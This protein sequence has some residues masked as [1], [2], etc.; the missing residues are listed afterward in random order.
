[1]T[2]NIKTMKNII[3][4]L[5]VVLCLNS[6]G[7]DSQTSAITTSDI[8]AS[9]TESSNNRAEILKREEPPAKKVEDVTSAVHDKIKSKSLDKEQKE[10]KQEQFKKSKNREKSCTDL[11]LEYEQL[12]DKIVSDKTN[13]ENLT[14]LKSW[15]ND[16]FHNTCLNDNAD[17]Q[18]KYAEINKKL[19]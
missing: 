19:G 5:F 15:A 18:K 16:I 8:P 10:I 4:L 7:S 11:I 12:I 6:C 9:V 14:K 17:Y 1:M 2:D 13:L 3:L